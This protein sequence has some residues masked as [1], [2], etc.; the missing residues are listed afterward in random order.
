MLVVALAGCG[1]AVV[2]RP[3]KA[4]RSQPAKPADGAEAAYQAYRRVAHARGAIWLLLQI[5]KR[6]SEHFRSDL[7]DADGKLKPR[8]FPRPPKGWLPAKPCCSFP[9]GL[10]PG[11]KMSR[12]TA[13]W[14]ALHYWALTE[15]RPVQYRYSSSG[16]GDG[17]TFVAEA[18]ADVGCNGQVDWYRFK[19]KGRLGKRPEVWGGPVEFVKGLDPRKAPLASIPVLIRALHSTEEEL[20]TAAVRDL[21]KHRSRAR[22]AALKLVKGDRPH[23]RLAGAR[24]LLFSLD[25]DLATLSPLLRDPDKLVREGLLE[26]LA[27]ASKQ[28]GVMLAPLAALLHVDDASTVMKAASTLCSITPKLGVPQTVAALKHKD[29][30]I[31]QHLLEVLALTA[32]KAGTKEPWQEVVLT[33]AIQ[34]LDDSHPDVRQAASGALAACRASGVKALVVALR[35][36]N[37]D[38]RQHAAIHLGGLGRQ[39]AGALPAL[40]KIRR[41]A[42]GETRRH[43][44]EAIRDIEQAMAAAPSRPSSK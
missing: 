24:V 34:R 21:P 43:L 25:R 36:K 38:V 27:Q 31:R 14:F 22:T 2:S 4:P 30:S 11:V 17:A 23:Q 8:Q 41:T 18:R 10:C 32:Q 26:A 28:R 42:R 44:I 6:S 5:G 19:G 29:P 39:A 12:I 20:H 40:R 15:P 13:P 33:A 37:K 7:R 3:K 16:T 1:P 9:G 35:H